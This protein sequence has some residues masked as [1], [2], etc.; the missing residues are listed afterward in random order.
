MG[1]TESFEIN[2]AIISL[3][4][5]TFIANGIL[6][7]SKHN[8]LKDLLILLWTDWLVA[9]QAMVFIVMDS[10]LHYF[11]AFKRKGLHVYNLFRLQYPQ[12]SSYTANFTSSNL[13]CQSA[14]SNIFY[15]SANVDAKWRSKFNASCFNC[16]LPKITSVLYGVLMS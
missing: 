4:M 6:K 13:V 14:L 7:Q 1:F 2:D 5:T 15:W 11:R 10:F 8:Q 16:Q 9:W 3:T 12:W